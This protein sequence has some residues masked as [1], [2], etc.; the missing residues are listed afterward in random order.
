M[1]TP[2]EDFQDSYRQAIAAK[3]AFNAAK[4]L[5]ISDAKKCKGQRDEITKRLHK[6]R[7]DLVAALAEAYK[8]G[9]RIKDDMMKGER[10]P[11]KH[12]PSLNRYSQIL[13]AI[14]HDQRSPEMRE[15]LAWWEKYEAA[16][17]A[18]DQAFPPPD[19]FYWNGSQLTGP[20]LY[21]DF[22]ISNNS[23]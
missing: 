4:A 3:E 16:A 21:Q 2:I 17:R 8:H 15:C 10:W 1:K 5:M 11:R 6:E 19:H 13:S 23:E 7:P 18:V 22:G 14:P 20:N 9:E 12:D